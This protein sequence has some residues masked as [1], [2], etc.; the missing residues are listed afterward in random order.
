MKFFQNAT[1]KCLK[2]V[3]LYQACINLGSLLA[4]VANYAAR[5]RKVELLFSAITYLS[6]ALCILAAVLSV[7][8]CIQFSL[9][10]AALA[11]HLG[12]VHQYNRHFHFIITASGSPAVSLGLQS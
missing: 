7:C 2:Y 11:L 5:A 10:F 12:F 8:I 1:L 3:P 4:T 6:L 9:H